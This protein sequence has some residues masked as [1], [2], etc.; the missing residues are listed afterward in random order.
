M[1]AHYIWG[2]MTSHLHLHEAEIFISSVPRYIPCQYMASFKYTTF[3]KSI[4][5]RAIEKYN[6]TCR[7][8]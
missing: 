8:C 5:V 3:T 4:K 2:V 1:E 6:K 7:H